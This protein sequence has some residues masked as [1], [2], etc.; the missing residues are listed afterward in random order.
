MAD[1][2]ILNTLRSAIDAYPDP[3]LGETLGA[4]GAVRDVSASGTGYKARIALGFPVGD[5]H[6]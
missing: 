3:Y 4:A 6:E 5:Y 2:S 1:D